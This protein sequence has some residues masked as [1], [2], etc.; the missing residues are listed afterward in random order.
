MH[1]ECTL[2]I[3]RF[4]DATIGGY[5][6]EP[7]EKN[8]DRN[9]N[10]LIRREVARIGKYIHANAPSVVK[11]ITRATHIGLQYPCCTVKCGNISC[12]ISTKEPSFCKSIVHYTPTYQ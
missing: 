6:A 7:L 3:K 5:I 12:V 4:R 9:E 2:Y 8:P 11:Y 1:F 10:E